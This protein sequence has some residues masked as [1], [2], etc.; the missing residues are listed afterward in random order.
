MVS[1]PDRQPPS[2]SSGRGI[3]LPNIAS[4][5]LGGAEEGFPPR[6][7]VAG[8]RGSET[9]LTSSAT[10]SVVLRPRAA[11]AH[12]PSTPASGVVP[13]G[14]DPWGPGSAPFAW[15]GTLPGGQPMVVFPGVVYRR[16]KTTLG[17]EMLDQSRRPMV[18]LPGVVCRPPKTFRARLEAD[19]LLDNRPVLLRARRDRV[20]ARPVRLE[21]LRSLDTWL[22]A[23]PDRVLRARNERSARSAR[24]NKPPPP[25]PAERMW[26]AAHS[27][28]WMRMDEERERREREARIA[29]II[30]CAEEQGSARRRTTTT[31][32]QPSSSSTTASVDAA[33]SSSSA[34]A[35][36]ASASASGS[37]VTSPPHLA[38]FEAYEELLASGIVA[39][40]DEQEDEGLPEEWRMARLIPDRAPSPDRQRVRVYRPIMVRREPGPRRGGSGGYQPS[41]SSPS[42]P[43][44]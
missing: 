6:G 1:P 39:D 20:D 14:Q 43:E 27:G 34:S 15:D 30:R 23:P 19:R 7:D 44:E 8:Q 12:P 9:Q 3:N 11:S 33:A 32:S 38:S 17:C 36:A 22:P 18:V 35:A 41:S 24:N 29:L 5:D 26:R 42:A 25:G 16:P 10:R 40:D 37:S 21:A 31:R 13:R 28:E 2:S 4:L